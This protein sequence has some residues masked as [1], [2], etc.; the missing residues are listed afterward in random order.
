VV[1]DQGGFSASVPLE[2]PPARGGLPLPLQITSGARGFGAVGLGWDI[3]LSYLLFDNSLAHRRPAYAPAAPAAPRSRVTVALPGRTAEMI[4]IGQGSWIGRYAPDL[5]MT[6]DASP[7]R[8]RV[9]DGGGLT[10]TFVLY[11]QLMGAGGS[12]TFPNDPE[13]GLWLLD[14]IT[15][16]GGATVQLTYTMPYVHVPGSTAQFVSIDL[17]KISYNPHP[18]CLRPGP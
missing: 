9:H 6:Y 18:P 17:T 4:P 11:A 14:T 13:S 16:P 3:P 10:Y 15:G 12:Y 5:S 8:W 1:T 7:V 2:L